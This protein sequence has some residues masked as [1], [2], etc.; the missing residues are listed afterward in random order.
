MTIQIIKNY[1]TEDD[2]NLY[3][4]EFDKILVPEPYRPSMAAALGQKNSFT[5]SQVNPDNP[6]THLRGEE[7]L[8]LAILKAS[9]LVN[10]VRETMEQFY[11]LELDLANVSFARIGKGGKNPLHSDSTKLDGSPWRDDGIP[12]ELEYSALVYCSQNKVDFSGGEVK[13]PLQDLEINPE[14]GMLVYFKG[15]VEHI[16]EVC[17]VTDGYRYTFVLFYAR[18]GNVSDGETFFTN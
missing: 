6:I 2:C 1:I 8:D 17:E 15:D 16:H 14:K 18:K 12:E 3:V 11:G 9:Q 10:D 7:S 13:F 4:S 5:A